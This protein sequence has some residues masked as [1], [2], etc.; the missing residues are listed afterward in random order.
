M[1]RHCIIYRATNILT[2]KVYIGQ[3]CRSLQGRIKAH[4]RV[5]LNSLIKKPK[6]Q[7]YFHNALLKYGFDKFN[8]DILCKCATQLEL[9]EKETEYIKKF[10]ST[11]KIFGY[12]LTEGGR[13]GKFTLEAKKNLSFGLKNYFKS[14]E[15]RKKQGRAQNRRFS[16]IEARIKHSKCHGGK[17]FYARNANELKKF[18]TQHEASIYTKTSQL[19][20]SCILHGKVKSKN[21]WIFSF[22]YITRKMY[23]DFVEQLKRKIFFAIKGDQKLEFTNKRQAAKQLNICPQNIIAVLRGARKFA[24]GWSFCYKFGAK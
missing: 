23:D 11:N 3:T 17:A 1:N 9:D 14:D 16:K 5:C 18:K 22:K 2:N 7:S 6:S 15:A 8:W 13:G 20:I 10:N 19:F 12:N 21:G 24:N 4:H